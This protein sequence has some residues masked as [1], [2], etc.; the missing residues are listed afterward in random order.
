MMQTIS[1]RQIIFFIVLFVYFRPYVLIHA[2]SFRLMSKI[3]AC[4]QHTF[5]PVFFSLPVNGICPPPRFNLFAQPLQSAHLSTGSTDGGYFSV[6]GCDVDSRQNLMS[7][8]FVNCFEKGTY[9]AD[10][11]LA[12]KQ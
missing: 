3:L 11:Y 1:I 8:P 9:I 5:F 6:F 12:S 7:Q 2:F 10:L 4:A